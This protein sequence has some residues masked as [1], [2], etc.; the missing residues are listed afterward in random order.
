[1]LTRLMEGA[2]L[3]LGEAV[4]GT[5]IG[6]AAWIKSKNRRKNNA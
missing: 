4:I 6:T 1:M 2:Y 5:A 3:V